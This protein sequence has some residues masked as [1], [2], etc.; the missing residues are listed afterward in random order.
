MKPATK[1]NP[2]WPLWATGLSA[3]LLGTVLSATVVMLYHVEVVRESQK[4]AAT[5]RSKISLLE[6]ALNQ[7]QPY[8]LSLEEA[9]APRI[10][11]VTVQPSPVAQVQVATVKPA[12][13]PVVPAV[14]STPAPP[15]PTLARPPANAPSVQPG[16]QV[17]PAAPVATQPAPQQHAVVAKPLPAAPVAQPAPA[18]PVKPAATSVAPDELAAAM[19]KKIEVMSM[20]RVGVA[21]L[22]ADTVEFASG[23]RVRT[24]ELF[25][26]GEK[27]LK[28]DPAD[29]RIVTNERQLIVFE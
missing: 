13:Q 1:L 22:H 4:T 20:A 2:S 11:P 25:P 15:P 28:V 6:V 14:P 12:Q 19:K 5:L 27:L 26:S 23:R 16:Q 24:G 21:K 9:P 17:K 7:A 18:A 8:T 29:G 3:G 10:E